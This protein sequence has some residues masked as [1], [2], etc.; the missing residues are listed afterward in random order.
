VILEIVIAAS[1][2]SSLEAGAEHP[3]GLSETKYV[4]H[5]YT[6]AIFVIASTRHHLS[7]RRIA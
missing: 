6:N 4:E 7:V 2:E 3:T 5:G 1:V